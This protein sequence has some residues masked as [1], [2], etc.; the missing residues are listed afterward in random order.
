LAGA[1]APNRPLDG[2]SLA[3][4][5]AGRMTERPKPIGFWS[6]NAN[7]VTKREPAAKP[8]IE[9]ALQEGTTPLVKYLAGKLTRSFQN[10]HQPPIEEADYAGPRVLLDNRYKLVMDG[11]RED[12]RV[13]LFDLRTDPAEET[14]LAETEPEITAEMKKRL[15]AWQSS[16]LQSLTG[17]DYR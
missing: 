1:S 9:P 12:G 10:F 8:Y 6:Y 16:V 15:R 3:M 13:E 2:I 14:N 5:I 4:L 17:A 7:R 11:E